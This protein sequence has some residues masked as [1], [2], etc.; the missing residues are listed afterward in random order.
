MSQFPWELVSHRLDNP[1]AS[2]Q[3]LGLLLELCAQAVVQVFG[4][5]CSKKAVDTGGPESSRR[6]A[7]AV[8]VS[9]GLRHRRED[10]SID[11]HLKS[12]DCVRP[13][14]WRRARSWMQV[15]G[16][17]LLCECQ[18][19]EGTWVGSLCTVAPAKSQDR[20]LG[21]QAWGPRFGAAGSDL[22]AAP[23][24]VCTCPSVWAEW[25]GVGS[26]RAQVLPED[27]Q[28]GRGHSCRFWAAE[29]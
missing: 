12:R 8:C 27:A 18:Q 7:G 1:Q 22:G 13:V 24:T 9:G 21:V 11:S 2:A 19:E 6:L 16:M 25:G 10:T 28:V 26:P 23:A 17:S 4:C 5:F 3:V 29:G 15:W 14:G 20:P